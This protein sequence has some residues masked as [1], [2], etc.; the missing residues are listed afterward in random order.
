MKRM[1]NTLYVTTQG[2]YLSKERETAVISINKKNILRVPLS[3]LDGIICFGQVSCSPHL[4]GHCASKDVTI[5]FLSEWGKFLARVVGPVSGNVMLRREQ[6]RKADDEI[7][8]AEI[9]RSVVI[10]KIY[11]SYS[12]LARAIRD[13]GERL[14]KSKLNDALIYLKSNAKKTSQARNVDTI[15]GFEGES[16]KIYFQVFDDLI[17]SQKEDFKFTGRN[18]RP[19]LDNVNALM[20]FIYSVLTHDAISALESVG[21]DPQVGFL[22]R[23]RPGRPGLA[24]DLLEE[25]RPAIADRLVL[26]LINRKQVTGEGFVK[27]ESGAVSM[28]EDVRKTLLE[29]YQKRKETEFFHPFIKEKI[30]YG[31][32]LFAQALLLSK[33][34]RGEIEEYP[35]FFWR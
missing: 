22:H 18:R 8:S 14:N 26:S 33:F 23:D 27:T 7:S 2:A 20:S 25:L 35:A 24:L 5:S 21:L 15:R 16:A 32:I 11:N 6:Y 17:V 28:D 12:V 13:Y 4:M 30:P 3:N 9:A 1:L 31:L 10:A 19:P 29:A 34:I